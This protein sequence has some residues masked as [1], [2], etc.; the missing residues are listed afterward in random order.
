M[1]DAQSS[2]GAAVRVRL[3]EYGRLTPEQR[4]QRNGRITLLRK[5]K[6]ARDPKY[7]ERINA[8]KRSKRAERAAAEGRV[9]VPKKPA[10]RLTEE[11]KLQRAY[12]RLTASNARE[13]WAYWLKVKA[14]DWWMR[15]YYM[16]SGKPWNNPRLSVA[17]KYSM[18]YELDSSFRDRQRE[19]TRMYKFSHPD[20]VAGWENS[21]GNRRK[22]NQTAMLADGTVSKQVVRSLVCETICAWCGCGIDKRNRQIDHITPISKGGAHSAL[23]LVATCDKCNMAKGSKLLFQWLPVLSEKILGPSGA[24]NVAGATTAGFR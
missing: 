3:G 16:E 20:I 15:V 11:V 1:A 4:R 21:A 23:N 13:A 2:A 9:F 7:R 10:I 17:E 14:P 12:A 8:Y 6:R 18:R 24:G 22:W 19:K 5:S